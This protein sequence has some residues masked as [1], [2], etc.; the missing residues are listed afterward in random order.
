MFKCTFC[1][2][3]HYRVQGTEQIAM[4]LCINKGLKDL[5][6]DED[7]IPFIF[8]DTHKDQKINRYCTEHNSIICSEC[9][10]NSHIN[11]G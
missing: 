6:V 7:N 10:F 1:A 5:L 4:S 3:E 8:C 11:H 9:A 2:S